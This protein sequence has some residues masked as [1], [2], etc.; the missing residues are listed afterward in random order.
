MS[1]HSDTLN[2]R[3][4]VKNH[5]QE[6]GRMGRI[7]QSI[8]ASLQNLPSSVLIFS[9]YSLNIHKIGFIIGKITWWNLL[10]NL[11]ILNLIRS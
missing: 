5:R 11:F 2:F 7:F 10:K 3:R 4:T 8:P 6:R 9:L 1:G